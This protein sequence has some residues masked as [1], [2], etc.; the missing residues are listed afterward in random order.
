[1][2]AYAKTADMTGYGNEITFTTAINVGQSY[3]GGIVAYILQPGDPGYI[4]GQTHGLI[5]APTDQSQSVVWSNGTNFYTGASGTAIGTGNSNT[6]IIVTKQGTGTYAAKL[7]YDLVL[8]GYNDWFMPSIDE[9][10]A[11]WLNRYSLSGWKDWC[12]DNDYMSSSDYNATDYWKIYWA[13]G[14]KTTGNYQ[15]SRAQCVRCIRAF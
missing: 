10:Y 6:N 9:M 5:A 11:V 14:S 7:C 4:A 13:N 3:R 8:G 15:K 1:V 2:R 12:C